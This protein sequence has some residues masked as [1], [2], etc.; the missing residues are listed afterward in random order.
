MP[1]ISLPNNKMTQSRN[2]ATFIQTAHV[3]KG[4]DCVPFI[5]GGALMQPS[6]LSSISPLEA[7]PCTAL[8]QTL[9]CFKFYLDQSIQEGAIY[10]N[11]LYRLAKQF[12]VD[13]RLQAYQYGYE[14]MGRDVLAFISVSN[15]RYVVWTKLGS[16]T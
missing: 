7:A 5:V 2:G 12:A 11:K 10:S 15:Q 16:P 4:S 3:A 14:L 9:T 1:L 8:E 13:E 6:T